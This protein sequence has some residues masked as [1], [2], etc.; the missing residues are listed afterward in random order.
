MEDQNR[1]LNGN[2]L[3]AGGNPIQPGIYLVRGGLHG[4]CM[5]QR[6]VFLR[7]DLGLCCRVEKLGDRQNIEDNYVPIKDLGLKFIAK[8]GDL[9]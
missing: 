4:N 5:D 6:E 8:V 1:T 2:Y 9:K 7:Q 3:D